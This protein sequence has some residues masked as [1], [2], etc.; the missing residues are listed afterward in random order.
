MI[1]GRL[2]LSH[3]CMRRRFAVFAGNNWDCPPNGHERRG[4]TLRVAF[5]QK[6]GPDRLRIRDRR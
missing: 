5:A 1:A 2:R 3:A 6:K 4:R